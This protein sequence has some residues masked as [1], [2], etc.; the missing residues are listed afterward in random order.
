MRL[1]GG[2]PACAGFQADGTGAAAA[3]TISG[4]LQHL[5]GRTRSRKEALGS[6]GKPIRALSAFLTPP[7]RRSEG[8]HAC[9][10]ASTHSAV[11]QHA[12]GEGAVAG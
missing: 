9:L 4:C 5:Q 12:G 2:A 7:Q 1:R 10:L 3:P 11:P 8:P 6:R